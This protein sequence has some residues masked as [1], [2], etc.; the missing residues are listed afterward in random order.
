M[1]SLP[2]MPNLRSPFSVDTQPAPQNSKQVSARIV[3]KLFC[4]AVMQTDSPPPSSINGVNRHA[5]GF[6]IGGT[7]VA[8]VSTAIREQSKAPSPLRSAGAVQNVG[9]AGEAVFGVSFF[10]LQSK[11]SFHTRLDS[12]QR[13]T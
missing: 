7:Y 12:R 5:D 6:C 13:I 11:E 2:G 10:S 9:P 3:K 4:M 1:V 8:S